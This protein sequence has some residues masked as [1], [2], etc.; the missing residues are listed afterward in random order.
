MLI[1]TRKVG[2]EI[3]IAEQIVISVLEVRGSQVRL[4]IVAPPSITIHRGEIYERIR[5]EN[6]RAGR[7]GHSE[8]G[9]LSERLRAI[10][11][12]SAVPKKPSTE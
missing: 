1:L 6:L 7:V 11:P 8:V 4:G 12:G 10:F 5:E 3:T 9:A 2:E